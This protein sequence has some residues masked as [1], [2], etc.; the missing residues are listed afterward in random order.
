MNCKEAYDKMF[1]ILDEQ[2]IWT[3]ERG[4]EVLLDD[5]D[6]F[7][8]V[9]GTSAY[10]A[11][12]NNFVEHWQQSQDALETAVW[13]VTKYAKQYDYDGEEAADYLKI[14]WQD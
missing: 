7:F 6:P 5:M 4:L 1:S 8:F 9:G 11:I 12:Y 10:P 14:H 2:Y 3:R 13:L